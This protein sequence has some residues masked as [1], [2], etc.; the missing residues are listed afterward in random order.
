VIAK[1]HIQ[2]NWIKQIFLFSL[3]MFQFLIDKT[4][5]VKQSIG[6]HRIKRTILF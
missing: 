6:Q 2:Q 4:K 1:Q 5:I 3:T